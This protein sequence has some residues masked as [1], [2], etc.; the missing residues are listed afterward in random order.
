MTN[1]PHAKPESTH[2][3]PKPAVVAPAHE[4]QTHDASK[5]APTPMKTP[6]PQVA[7]GHTPS[8]TKA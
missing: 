1:M 6:A 4:K 5:A 8:H 2:T 7:P 3:E